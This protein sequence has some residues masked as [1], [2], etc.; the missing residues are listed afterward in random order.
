MNTNVMII[1]AY[2]MIH[3]C[4][5]QWGGGKALGPNQIVYNF[6]R[7]LKATIAQFK[8]DKVYFPLDG[9]PAARL[10]AYPEYKGTRTV[11]TT[12]PEEL[13]Y[14]E[15]FKQ[16]KREIIRLVKNYL[17][18]TTM[19]HENYE[20]DDLVL[21]IVDKYHSDDNVL[22]VSSDTDFI[23]ILNKYP[24]NVQLFN[25]ITSSYRQNTEYD[26]VSWKAMVGDKADNIPGVR[27]IGKKTAAKILSS[28]DG[29]SDRMKDLKFSTEYNLS[30]ELI[31]L[32]PVDES[33]IETYEPDFDA[34]EIKKSFENMGFESM[35]KESY[36]DNFE[37]TF[38]DLQNFRRK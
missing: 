38:N 10:E 7:T 30:Y 27:G 25:P 1:D 18:V 9:K 11:V 8:P 34:E 23:Q 36:Y 29:L 4:R 22:I 15:D 13:A 19:F 2:N 33:G 32:Q 12:D 24:D 26:Y 21:H 6:L 17:P 5:F 16:Q 14:W 28:P 35:M 31:K 20:C 3:R 37:S